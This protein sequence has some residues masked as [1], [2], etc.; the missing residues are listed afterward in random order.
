MGFT[1][2]EV[3]VALSIV[4]VT[5]GAM[6]KVSQAWVNS[7]ERQRDVFLAQICAENELIK[8]RLSRQLPDVGSGDFSCTQAGR[9]FAG[10]ISVQGTPNPS[11]RRVDVRVLDGAVSVLSVSTVM[12]RF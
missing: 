6:M 7:T 9:S 5:L 4:A 12:G 2:V 8:L 1:L 10:N 3:L 11:F